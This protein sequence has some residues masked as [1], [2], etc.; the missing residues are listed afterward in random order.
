MNDC[1]TSV[2]H[3]SSFTLLC[4]QNGDT[5]LHMATRRRKVEV[6]KFLVQRGANVHSVNKVSYSSPIH[7]CCV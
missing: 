7:F 4:T 2:Y 3:I 5:A 6:V 1:D